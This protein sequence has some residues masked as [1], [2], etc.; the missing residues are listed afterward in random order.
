MFFPVPAQSE[1]E[2]LPS[3]RYAYPYFCYFVSPESN[4]T[5][6]VPA[7]KTLEEKNEE[8][9]V[10]SE[11]IDSILLKFDSNADGYID[12]FEFRKVA[13]QSRSEQKSQS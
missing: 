13:L 1:K 7:T 8:E 9:K 2:P 4:S 11:N 3:T 12:Y 5:E 10:L 6:E